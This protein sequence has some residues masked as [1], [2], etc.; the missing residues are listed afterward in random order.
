M[1]QELDG[2]R[3]FCCLGV[4][5]ELSRKY[6]RKNWKWESQG[7]RKYGSL[8][9]ED[10]TLHPLVQEWAG[11]GLVG[12]PKFPHLG[13]TLADLNDSGVDFESI[14]DIIEKEL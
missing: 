12:N 9:G 8:E 3:F 11:E 7:Y 5:T 14:A 10:Q 6:L 4:L 13:T 1:T 2:E